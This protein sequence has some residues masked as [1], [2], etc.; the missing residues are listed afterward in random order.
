MSTARPLF[1]VTLLAALSVTCLAQ[2][3]GYEDTPVIPGTQWRVHD[4]ARPNPP[5]VEP[6][7]FAAL[8]APKDAII[9]FDG[10]DLSKWTGRKDKASWKVENGYM[11]VTRT[12]DIRTR[13][14]FG[15]IQ[16]HLEFATPSEVKG[17]SQ[18]RGNS[19]LFLMG[20]YEVQILDSYKN[21]SYADG[22]CGALYGQH[23]PLRNACR[24]P[25]E[26]QTYDVVF[27]APR[28]AE[29]GK[30]ISPARVTVIH[31]GV[32]VQNNQD[33]MG[34]TR[35]RATTSYKKHAPTGPIKLQ[36]HGNPMRFRNIWVR[37]L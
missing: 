17:S 5:V 28:F 33:F 29:D 32:V 24:A 25:G 13:D 20:M 19:G 14:T 34:P 36:D 16:L 31:N 12:G 21:R 30:L 35:H 3:V 27:R 37:K 10:T 1:A 18:G 2:G 6:G 8:E 23:P 11:E 26:W 7:P 22:Q 9:L 4:K 15:D